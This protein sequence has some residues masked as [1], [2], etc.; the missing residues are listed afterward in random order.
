LAVNRFLIIAGVF[1][2]LVAVAVVA[3]AARNAPSASARRAWK[4]K[5][6]AEISSRVADSAWP[7]N[8][9]ARLQTKG[10]NGPG[11]SGTWLSERLI[12]MRNGDWV[13]Y[14]AICQ[15]ENRR[16]QDL[17]IGRGSDGSWYYSTYHFCIDMLELRME[18][19]PPD[20]LAAFSQTYH[21]RQFDGHSDECLGKTWPPDS[22]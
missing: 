22:K 1:S 16:I 11:N 20:D 15:K 5:A 18:E 21:L 13:A 17:F 14:A 4:E 6:I 10:I 12:V 8:E 19:N 7:S 3:I 2:V 9:L